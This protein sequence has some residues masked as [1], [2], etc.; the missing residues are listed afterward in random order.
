MKA[1]EPQDLLKE[2]EDSGLKVK[3]ARFCQEYLVD[4]NAT[5]AA[6]RA[7]YSEKTAYSIGSENLNKPEIRGQ[8]NK[9]LIQQA[10]RLDITADKVLVELAEIG[11]SDIGGDIKASDKTRAMELLGKNLR[12]FSDKIEFTGKDGGPIET[13]DL[14]PN[15][16]ARRIAATL[17]K[18]DEALEDAG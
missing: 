14:S 7:G 13:K 17:T 10:K 15:D 12:L 3:Q 16:L 8:I 9:L 4:N 11:F 5:K 6:I 1:K 18:V 2:I